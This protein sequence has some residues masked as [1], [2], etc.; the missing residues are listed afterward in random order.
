MIHFALLAAALPFMDGIAGVYKT[1]FPNAL[2]DGTKYESENILEVVPLDDKSAYVRMELQFSN[3]HLGGIYGVATAKD[4]TLVLDT[5]G[6]KEERCVIEWRFGKEEV[7]AV[8]DYAATPGCNYYHGTR[9][10]LS[11]TFKT[12][13]KRAIRYMK[14]LKDSQQYKDALAKQVRQK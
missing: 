7:E 13:S 14:R 5:G 9:G 10:L 8:T 11:A 3:G 2:V 6:P 4:Q 12:K 1:R